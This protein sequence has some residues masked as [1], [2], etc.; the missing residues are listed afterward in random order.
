[1]RSTLLILGALTA[2]AAEISPPVRARL[3]ASCVAC[4]SGP[5]AQGGLDLRSLP[6]TLQSPAVRD[7]WIRIYDR[8]DKGE[9]PPLLPQLVALVQTYALVLL[10]RARMHYQNRPNSDMRC[11]AN[12]M[13]ARSCAHHMRGV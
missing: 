5:A 12:G 13:E 7:R 3:E 2:S 4:H 8:V 9:M 1:M 10:R 11:P 6:S